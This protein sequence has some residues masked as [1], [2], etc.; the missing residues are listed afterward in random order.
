MDDHILSRQVHVNNRL[1]YLAVTGVTFWDRPSRTGRL[2][3]EMS[4]NVHWQVS[5]LMLA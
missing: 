2:S 3:I 1:P 4:Q 5:V